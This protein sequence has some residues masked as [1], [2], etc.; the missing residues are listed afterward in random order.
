MTNFKTLRSPITWFRVWAVSGA[1]PGLQIESQEHK[2]PHQNDPF[3]IMS[4]CGFI[5]IIRAKWCSI[6]KF[7]IPENIALE[8]IFPQVSVQNLPFAVVTTCVINATFSWRG[9][10]KQMMCCQF[11]HIK[12][13]I[14]KT[15]LSD[16]LRPQT[17]A[18]TKQSMSSDAVSIN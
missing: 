12:M 5:Y 11:C 8:F 18:S 2:L 16:L 14:R 9:L 6:P 7:V 1:V 4:V 15:L 3:C 13:Q 17:L 10:Q